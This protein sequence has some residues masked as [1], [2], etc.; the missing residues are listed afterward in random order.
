MSIIL[1]SSPLTCINACLSL[2]MSELENVRGKQRP[3]L[4]LLLCVTSWSLFAL[5]I[6]CC[7]CVGS[8]GPKAL[9]H[10]LCCHTKEAVWSWLSLRRHTAFRKSRSRCQVGSCGTLQHRGVEFMRALFSWAERAVPSTISRVGIAK[11]EV[12]SSGQFLQGQES[13]SWQGCLFVRALRA[14]VKLNVKHEALGRD[15]RMGQLQ[16]A[17]VQSCLLNLNS[18]S[19]CLPQSSRKLLKAI[20]ISVGGVIKKYIVYLN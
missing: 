7:V 6:G 15:R 5:A 16:D 2:M 9:S 8:N 19:L 4:P 20:K 1:N 10:R 17:W 13:N 11:L 14:G 12:G 3:P 18:F